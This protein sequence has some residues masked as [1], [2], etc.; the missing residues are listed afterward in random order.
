MPT[1][2]VVEV[3]VIVSKLLGAETQLYT[4]VGSIELVSK[5]DARDFTKRKDGL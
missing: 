5:V 1:D 4:K 2:Q 3:T